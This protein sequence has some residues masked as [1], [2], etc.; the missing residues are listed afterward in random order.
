MCQ[1]AAERLREAGDENVHYFSGL[2][3]FGEDLAA[4]CLPD[5]L[6]PNGDG[7]EAMGRNFAERVLEKLGF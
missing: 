5:N 6:H 7:Y 3:L 1:R 2:E 4:T